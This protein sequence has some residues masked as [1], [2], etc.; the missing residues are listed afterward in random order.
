MSN[1]KTNTVAACKQVVNHLLSE[2]QIKND[3]IKNL[4]SKLSNYE[5][6]TELQLKNLNESWFK[7]YKK[8]SGDHR[9]LEKEYDKLFSYCIT[10]ENEL[11]IHNNI[12][13]VD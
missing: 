13:A 11:E 12:D 4:E 10:I 9:E 3:I 7:D 1:A 8:L 5:K 6:K 2:L